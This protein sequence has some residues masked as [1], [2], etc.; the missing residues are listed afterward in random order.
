MAE[1]IYKRY[2]VNKIYKKENVSST[3]HEFGQYDFSM[4]MASSYTFSSSS[5]RFTIPPLDVALS[6]K[7]SLQGVRPPVDGGYYYLPLVG[8]PAEHSDD[9]MGKVVGGGFSPYALD[10]ASPNN[11]IETDFIAE[12]GWEATDDWMRIRIYESIPIESKGKYIDEVTA[13]DGAYPANGIHDGYW[14]IKGSM[15]NEPPNPPTRLTVPNEIYGGDTITISWNAGTDPEGM[16]LTYVVVRNTGGNGVIIGT[17]TELS[18]QDTIDPSWE[19]VRYFVRSK[20][21]LGLESTE[22][23]STPYITIQQ[24]PIAYYNDNGVIKKITE[25]FYNDNGV[26]KKVSLVY[27]NNGKISTTQ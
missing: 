12:F 2:T 24:K 8:K 1:Y 26:I 14:Y 25:C 17:T 18:I 7:N 21:P 19:K 11:F 16:P 23:A 3:T 20:D 10:G 9:T 5:G 6:S 22:N 27:N 15:V 13:E 4:D